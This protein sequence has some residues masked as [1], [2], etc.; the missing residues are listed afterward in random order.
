MQDW[1]IHTNTFDITFK[2]PH[3]NKATRD[4]WNIDVFS[5]LAAVLK[6]TPTPRRQHPHKPIPHAAIHVTLT[7][8]I[9][10]TLLAIALDMHANGANLR[11]LVVT[12][13]NKLTGVHSRGGSGGGGA[14]RGLPFELVVGHADVAA[15][16]Q[17]ALPVKGGAS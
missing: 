6:P 11:R 3:T 13:S 5:R 16:V 15:L 7:G 17:P 9:N 8:D 1:L 4:T 2:C 10:D 12:G 14:A